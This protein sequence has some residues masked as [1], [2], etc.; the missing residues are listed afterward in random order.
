MATVSKDSVLMIS[1]YKAQKE[2]PAVGAPCRIRLDNSID[3]Q[4]FDYGQSFIDARKDDATGTYA[5]RSARSAGWWW[6]VKHGD[7]TGIYT[8]DEVI[9][10]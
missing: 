8:M 5:G 10:L 9:D 4:K 3:Q 6:F 2:F 7:Q 1:Q